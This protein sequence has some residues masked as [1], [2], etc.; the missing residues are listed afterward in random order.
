MRA[1]GPDPID[2]GTRLAESSEEMRRERF[3]IEAQGLR[4]PGRD[5]QRFGEMRVD[6]AGFET[7]RRLELADH[8]PPG[9][10]AARTESVIPC[11]RVRESHHQLEFAIRRVR[12]A[13]GPPP[14]PG[15]H[16][17]EGIRESPSL[18]DAIADHAAVDADHPTQRLVEFLVPDPGAL[19]QLRHRTGNH[20]GEHQMT[21]VVQK[22]RE[23]RGRRLQIRD[24]ADPGD[25]RS[26]DGRGDHRMSPQ[27]DRDRE[28]GIASEKAADLDREG[29]RSDLVETEEDDR[30][31]EGL[32][33]LDEVLI[34]ASTERQD[35]RREG[36]FR[37]EDRHHL[38]DSGG[39]GGGD[40]EQSDRDRAGRRKAIDAIG[41]DPNPFDDGFA[42]H[43]PPPQA[44]STPSMQS[45]SA[46]T[47]NGLGMNASA[48][49]AISSSIS[50]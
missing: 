50:S 12:N 32:D 48:P 28:F 30:V 27:I 20:R 16:P 38:V 23:K 31:F 43:E 34:A 46:S 18:G 10:S 9:T 36:R 21:E 41:Q 22:T 11:N 4:R 6:D 24:A 37:R 39:R 26:G 33:L 42:L 15:D 5:R 45:M 25:E 49:A 14:G 1:G 44:V 40:F 29:R 13:R 35:P 3:T 7:E 2:F 47:W 8:A 17:A 19:R